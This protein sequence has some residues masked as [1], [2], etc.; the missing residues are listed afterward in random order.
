MFILILPCRASID[1]LV[2]RE[3]EIRDFSTPS[4][5]AIIGRYFF[6]DDASSGTNINSKCFLH[7]ILFKVE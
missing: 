3:N 7:N 6:S 2:M 4:V 1:F 5:F